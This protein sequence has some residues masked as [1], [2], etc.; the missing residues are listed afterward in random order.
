MGTNDED[1]VKLFV[2]DTHKPLHVLTVEVLTIEDSKAK[3]GSV[4][5]HIRPAALDPGFLNETAKLIPR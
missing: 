1:A 2:K 4:D 3:R 5:S